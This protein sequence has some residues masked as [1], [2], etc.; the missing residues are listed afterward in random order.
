[1]KIKVY[2]DSDFSGNYEQIFEGTTEQFLIDNDYDDFVTEQCARLQN[3]NII[4]F[5]EIS[6]DW[7][8][9][10]VITESLF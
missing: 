5:R 10:K 8:I 1:M 2:N 7:R 9:E 6:G 3:E 4:E